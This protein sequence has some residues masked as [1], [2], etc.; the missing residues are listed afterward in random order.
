MLLW[1]LNVFTMAKNTRIDINEQLNCFALKNAI[2][3]SVKKLQRKICV[4]KLFPKWISYH[5]MCWCLGCT[6]DTPFGSIF[7]YFF[8]GYEK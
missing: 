3:K 2:K 6:K 4:L 5:K 7:C 8:I 1:H